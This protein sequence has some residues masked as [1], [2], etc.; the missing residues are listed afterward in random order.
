METVAILNAELEAYDPSLV[1]KPSVIAL[2]KIDLSDGKEVGFK[3][4]K[5]ALAYLKGTVF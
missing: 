5:Y 1:Q 2:N 3:M 4:F